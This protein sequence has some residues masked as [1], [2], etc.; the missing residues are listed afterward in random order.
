MEEYLK[1]RP[2]KKV[3]QK[4]EIDR[5]RNQA[6]DKIKSRLLPDEKI[7]KIILIGSSIKD[8]FGEYDP[9]GFRGSLFSDFD[10]IIFVE[11]DYIIPDWL[12]REPDG[13]PFSED[14][15]NLAYRNKKFVDKKYDI[16]VFFLKR[17]NFE[18][19]IIQ[20]QGELAGIPMTSN[21]MHKNFAVYDKMTV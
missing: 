11:D 17:T 9:P 5:L 3:F 19:P 10:F 2:H 7:I 8:S 16:E 20:E 13:K 6:I 12:N 21:T 14:T 15:M 18:N 1:K 4:I